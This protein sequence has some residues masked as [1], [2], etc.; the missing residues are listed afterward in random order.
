MR[1]QDGAPR[2]GLFADAVEVQ[3][4][5]IIRS[6]R[7]LCREKSAINDG[8]RFIE[9]STKEIFLPRI[10]LDS[11]HCCSLEILRSRHRDAQ[12]VF[13]GTTDR[14]RIEMSILLYRSQ[15]YLCSMP[16][17]LARHGLNSFIS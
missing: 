15:P 5:L 11:S 17:K 16:D 9:E 6:R 2:N 13:T 1:Y 10:V 7:A 12:R 8:Q 4:R 14:M 3:C